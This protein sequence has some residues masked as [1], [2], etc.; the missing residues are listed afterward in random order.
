MYS[1]AR[2]A[3]HVLAQST[4]TGSRGSGN[5]TRCSE[6]CVRAARAGR[7]GHGVVVTRGRVVCRWLAGALALAALLSPLG[8]RAFTE[9]R[10]YFGDPREG[11]GGGRWFTGSPA[12]GHGCSVCHTG[13]AP[14]TVVLEGLPEDGYVPGEQYDVRIAWPAFAARADALR[15]DGEGPPGMGL[16]AELVAETGYGTG[17][18]EIA[19]A[20]QAED[21]ELCVLPEGATAALL[22]GVRPGEPTVEEGTHCIADGLGQR[23]LATVLSCG[24]RELRFRWTAPDEAQGAIWLSAGFVA[25]EHAE[26]T[27]END[28]VTELS[29]VLR[30]ADARD[31]PYETE[32]HQAC[33]V[34][35]GVGERRAGQPIAWW[36]FGAL[37]LWAVRRRRSAERRGRAWLVVGLIA[38]VSL[39]CTEDDRG[40]P[41]AGLFTPGSTLG[42]VGNDDDGGTA[43][44]GGLSER[45]RRDLEDSITEA[46][47][48]DRCA[49][50]DGEAGTPGNFVAAFETATYGGFYEPANCGAVWIEDAEGAFVA[51]AHVWAEL[52]L[53][54]LF[55]W[56][57]RRCKDALPV[58]AIATATLADHSQPHV[59]RWDGRDATGRV[60]PDGAYVLNF[61]ITEDELNFGRRTEIPFEKGPEPF[62]IEPEDGETVRSLRIEWAPSGGGA[63]P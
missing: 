38:S 33:G 6:R 16:V 47:G 35:G 25:T 49:A 12:E 23:C 5:P 24:A 34:A 41:L 22:F 46:S 61:E 14:E 56:D 3:A 20:E 50:I 54:N 13:P 9:P 55:V 18:I 2:G 31:T 15:A 17:A 11:G 48:Q 58:D 39:G 36:L 8:A 37:G 21:D 7:T 29:V 60:A 40:Y 4:L 43:D 52:R 51:T 63:S 59:A 44:G 57:A 19:S 62:V 30:P 27:A 1:P 45:E 42:A 28:A 53:R 32:L 26:G 10:T